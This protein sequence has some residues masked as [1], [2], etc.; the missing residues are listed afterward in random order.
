MKNDDHSELQKLL[1]LKRYEEP[2]DE[3][4]DNFVW[5]ARQRR[6]T[7]ATSLQMG[8]AARVKAQLAEILRP[9]WVLGAGLGA[10][11][12]GVMAAVLLWSNEGPNVSQANIIPASTEIDFSAVPIREANFSRE[13][14][15]LSA[16]SKPKEF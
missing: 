3:Y 2:K 15:D 14:S 8:F 1:R 5:E 4:F 11:Y 9:K 6:A 7:E 10:A 13:L 16:Q 12:A